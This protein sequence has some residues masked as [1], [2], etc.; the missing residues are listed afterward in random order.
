MNKNKILAVMVSVILV[1]VFTIVASTGIFFGKEN[2]PDN[3]DMV[4]D[5]DAYLHEFLDALHNG[6]RG[7]IY[8]EY[9]YCDDLSDVSFPDDGELSLVDYR[10]NDKAQLSNELWIYAIE[11]SIVGMQEEQWEDG[12]RESGEMIMF[13]GLIEDEYKVITH[14]THIPM[15]ICPAGLRHQL[16]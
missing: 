16:A 14:I 7:E 6:L 11:Y 5:A 13:V 4:C 3:S 8:K 2:E 15:E 9:V 1:A 12:Y 10:V